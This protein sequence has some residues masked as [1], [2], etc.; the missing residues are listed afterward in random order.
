MEKRKTNLCKAKTAEGR[1][2]RA[3][4][5]ATGLCFFHSNPNLASELGRKGGRSKRNQVVEELAPLPSLDTMKAVL[6]VSKGLFGELYAGKRPPKDTQGLV[7]LLKLITD[8]IRFTNLEERIAQ[9]EQ[10][11]A[12]SD[13][14]ARGAPDAPHGQ[15]GTN[16]DSVQ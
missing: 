14:G 12:Q 7:R 16:E 6:E 11:R 8:S 5:T 9:L 2:C 13:E 1:P 15:T 4:A 10:G 3:A